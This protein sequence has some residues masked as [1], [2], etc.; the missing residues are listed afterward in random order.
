M[1]A[2]KARAA[3]EPFNV[4]ATIIFILAVLHTFVAPKS[5]IGVT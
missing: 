4:V 3:T 2:I 1:D 5:A